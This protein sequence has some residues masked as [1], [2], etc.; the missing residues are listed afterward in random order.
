MPSNYGGFDVRVRK[1]D[2]TEIV[3]ANATIKVWRQD[4]NAD[5]GITLTTDATGWLA[6]GTL[7]GN[8][9]TPVIFRLEKYQGRTAFREVTTT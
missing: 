4:T 8:A 9:G 6:G 5:L 2:G 7:S 1:N 3:C